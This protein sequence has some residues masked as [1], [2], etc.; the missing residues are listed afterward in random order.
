MAGIF[1]AGDLVQKTGGGECSNNGF[2]TTPFSF[3]GLTHLGHAH[4]RILETP[5]LLLSLAHCTWN[6][7]DTDSITLVPCCILRF[8]RGLGSSIIGISIS[9]DNKNP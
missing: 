7:A 1:T 9:T 3:N 6:P 8:L 2:G 4:Y 5:D